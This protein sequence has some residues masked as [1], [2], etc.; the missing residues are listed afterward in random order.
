MSLKKA[1]FYHRMTRGGKDLKNQCFPIMNSLN[2][3]I[4]ST[5]NP[6]PS[7]TTPALRGGTAGHGA[8]KEEFPKGKI[9][10]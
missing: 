6:N 8:G 5:L 3:W 2:K 9:S 7:D 4:S 1:D 10:S